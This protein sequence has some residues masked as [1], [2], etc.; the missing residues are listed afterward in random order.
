[1]QSSVISGKTTVWNA[2]KKDWFLLLCLFISVSE[3]SA[4]AKFFI[5]PAF[6]ILLLRGNHFSQKSKY[7]AV[8]LIVFSVF[9]LLPYFFRVQLSSRTDYMVYLF[10][11]IFYMVGSYLGSKYKYDERSLVTI[12]Y[13]MLLMYALIHV[14][15]LIYSTIVNRGVIL[16][17]RLVLDSEDRQTTGATLYAIYVSVI[18]AGFAFIFMPK[19]SGILRWIRV[20]GIVLAILATWGMATTVTRTSVVEA[21][22]VLVFSA[23]MMLRDRDKKNGATGFLVGAIVLLSVGYYFYS[24]SNIAQYVEAFEAR[25]EMAGYDIG[26]AGGRFQR[27]GASLRGISMYP[28]GTPNTKIVEE[29]PLFGSY[30]HNMWLDV[31]LVGGW[32][33]LFILVI[34]S[35]RNIKQSFHLLHDKSY[36]YTT[37]LYFFS[38][39]L[40]FMLGSFVEPVLAAVYSHFLVY[41]VF[42]GMVSEMNTKPL[43][44]N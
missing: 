38:L 34:I 8:W 9:Y 18:I 27:W 1:M 4:H 35:I 26:S 12:L 30:G 44:T 21:V 19:Q 2:V 17:N 40:V 33:P 24:N 13:L 29:G 23:Y 16:D 11:P 25:N 10:P 37:R 42:C 39:L 32:I 20:F 7:T 14:G 5:L 43:L 31:G 36:G 3:L 15:T 28:L 41:L 6:F 22:V